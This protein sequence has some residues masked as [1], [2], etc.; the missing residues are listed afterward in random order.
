M[1]APLLPEGRN[2]FR[3]SIPSGGLIDFNENARGFYVFQLRKYIIGA[4]GKGIHNIVLGVFGN[5]HEKG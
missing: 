2:D 4:G 5:C 3:S 1:Q